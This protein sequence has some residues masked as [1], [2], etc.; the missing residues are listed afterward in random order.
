[1]IINM[2]GGGGTQPTGTKSITANGTYD[3]TEYASAQV[4]VPNPSSGTLNITSNGTYNVTNYANVSVSVQGALN[5]SISFVTGRKFV[6]GSQPN[7]SGSSSTKTVYTN[8]R[9]A[10]SSKYDITST[11]NIPSGTE[12]CKSESTS[13]MTCLIVSNTSTVSSK[14]TTSA[15]KELVSFTG[16]GTGTVS[17]PIFMENSSSTSASSVY[18]YSNVSGGVGRLTLNIVSGAISSASVSFPNSAYM[19]YGMGSLGG[20][21]RFYPYINGI[22]VTY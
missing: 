18:L 21:W 5:G 14:F 3:V 15:I 19:Q 1:M 20:Y 2:N 12:C 11:L 16:S 17:I 8:S 22:T 7:Y 4:N 13:S 6:S 10:L 9:S